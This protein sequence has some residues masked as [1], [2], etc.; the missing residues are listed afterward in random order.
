LMTDERRGRGRPKRKLPAGIG[1]EKDVVV[2]LNDGV[3][4]GAIRE[5]RRRRRIPPHCE[6]YRTQ[7]GER[8][9]RDPDEVTALVRAGEWD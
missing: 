3:T 1:E 6:P 8:H 4:E 7:W 2:A 9:G 5:L